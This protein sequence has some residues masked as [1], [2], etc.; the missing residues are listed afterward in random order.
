L[1]RASRWRKKEDAERPRGEEKKKEGRGKKK[2][3]GEE[4]KE[5]EREKGKNNLSNFFGNCDS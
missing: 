1:R 3:W 5:S 2:I 4:R